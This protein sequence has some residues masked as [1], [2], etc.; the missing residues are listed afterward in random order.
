MY[1]T[2]IHILS[3]SLTQRKLCFCYN[4]QSVSFVQDNKIPVDAD[5][6]SQKRLKYS[7]TSCLL[8]ESNMTKI[9][10]MPKIWIF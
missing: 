3:S 7:N 10:P 6:T 4:D 9:H 5:V 1:M 8:R 2:R